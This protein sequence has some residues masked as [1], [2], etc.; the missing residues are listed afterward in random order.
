MARTAT[1]RFV[2]IFKYFVDCFKT[3]T[4]YLKFL[5]AIQGKQANPESLNPYRLWRLPH[6]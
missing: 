4:S 1:K 3:K 2:S 6:Q 5:A